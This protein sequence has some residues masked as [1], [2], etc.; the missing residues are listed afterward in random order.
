M[1]GVFGGNLLQQYSVRAWFNLLPVVIDFL[2]DTIR[3]LW[4]RRSAASS[5]GAFVTQVQ[6]AQAYLKAVYVNLRQPEDLLRTVKVTLEHDILQLGARGFQDMTMPLAGA[7]PRPRT[8]V[9]RMSA[10][11][12]NYLREKLDQYG[13]SDGGLGKMLTRIWLSDVRRD[14]V[15]YE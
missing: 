3:G 11:R 4:A 1:N 13:L 10:A 5:A 14:E 8:L 7:E 2:A 9:L 6:N 15:F 12:Q